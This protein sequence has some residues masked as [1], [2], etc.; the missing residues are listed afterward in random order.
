VAQKAKMQLAAP[1]IKC[2]IV[3]HKVT[4][5]LSSQSQA[6]IQWPHCSQCCTVSTVSTDAFNFVT[7]KIRNCGCVRWVLRNT[8]GPKRDK[9]YRPTGVNYGTYTPL[10]GDL[11]QSGYG[12]DDRAI[13]VRSLAEGKGFFLQSMCPDRLW[14]PPSLL[15]KGNRGSFPRG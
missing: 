12:L 9:E 10:T 5:Q 13:E 14:S 2:T 8:S 11:S 3:T 7:A 1:Y 4:V 6:W 15:C